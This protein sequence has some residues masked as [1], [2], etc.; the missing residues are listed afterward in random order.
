MTRTTCRTC[1]CGSC[2]NKFCVES[3]VFV[4]RFLDV[5]GIKG[6]RVGWSV[7]VCG[8]LYGGDVD[9][10]GGVGNFDHRVL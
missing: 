7:T 5:F 1:L 9:L 3:G 10:I 8:F 4:G 2:G 6:G